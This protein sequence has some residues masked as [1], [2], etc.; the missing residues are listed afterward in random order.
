MV[1]NG[2]VTLWHIGEVDKKTRMNA[3]SRR[4]FFPKA[5]VQKDIKTMVTEGGLKT[6]DVIK[7]RI[8]GN[9][10]VEIQNGD[11]LIVGSCMDAEP[12]KNAFTVMGFADNR[13]GSPAV[14]HWKV[15]CG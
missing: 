6:A 8:P 11:K 7:I 1:T 5:S 14:R 2:S 13:K 12:P 3:P 10:D 15:I 4:Q 9:M